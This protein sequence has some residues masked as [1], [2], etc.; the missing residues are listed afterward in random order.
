MGFGKLD[1]EHLGIGE[2]E[3]FEHVD[4]VI[5]LLKALRSEKLV[6]RFYLYGLDI[7]C[8]GDSLVLDLKSQLVQ[9]KF[10]IGLVRKGDV[11]KDIIVNGVDTIHLTGNSI[12]AAF[13]DVILLLPFK[14][15]Y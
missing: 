1:G 3:L 10:E 11:Q 8:F 4:I 14:C 9:I 15:L 7:G 12:L 6:F 13:G 2:G 5:F